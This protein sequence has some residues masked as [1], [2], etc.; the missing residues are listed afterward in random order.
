MVQAG[1]ISSHW[2]CSDLLKQVY[3][4]HIHSKNL[5]FEVIR[6]GVKKTVKGDEHLDFFGQI[7]EATTN[8]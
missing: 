2:L 4:Y 1:F 3:N 7:I 6:A 5:T 8:L